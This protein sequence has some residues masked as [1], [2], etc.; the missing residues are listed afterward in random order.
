MILA[1]FL[2]AIVATCVVMLLGDQLK[3][4]Y[5]RP[6]GYHKPLQLISEVVALKKYKGLIYVFIWMVLIHNNCVE[7][8]KCIN[9]L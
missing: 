2:A 8:D 1:T 7:I 4:V 5:H 6:V 9:R 3:A